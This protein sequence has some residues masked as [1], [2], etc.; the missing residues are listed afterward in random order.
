MRAVDPEIVLFLGLV[1]GLTLIDKA[2]KCPSLAFW[3][4][5]WKL[6]K[7]NGLAGIAGGRQR[8]HESR[9]CTL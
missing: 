3:R 1:L 6:R 2:P 9:A 4:S 5:A 7:I 8:W